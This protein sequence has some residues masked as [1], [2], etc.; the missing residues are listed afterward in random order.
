LSASA[1]IA[2]ATPAEPVAP[3][4]GA[5]SSRRAEIARIQNAWSKFRENLRQ[6]AIGDHFPAP[7]K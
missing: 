2:K 1:K 4:A 3:S 5:K 6:L 7:C